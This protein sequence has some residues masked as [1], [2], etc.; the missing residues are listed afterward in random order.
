MNEVI[1]ALWE[2][3]PDLITHEYANYMIQKLIG[4]CS[5]AQRVK[6][7]TRLQSDIPGIA[8][9]KQGTHSLQTL[10]T[11]FSTGE[12]FDLAINSIKT[13]FVTLAQH[14]NATHFLQKI[15]SLFPLSHTSIF[16]EMVAN[17]FL[18]YAQDK[19]AMCVIKQ[20]VKKISHCEGNLK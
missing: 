5:L 6:I 14:P 1:A 8:R 15:I 19:H 16:V 17:D 11:L 10:I 18:S 3:L 2:E 12:E 7:V 20:M 13:S 9:N 4:V